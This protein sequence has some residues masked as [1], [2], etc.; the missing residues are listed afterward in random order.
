MRR[1]VPCLVIAL[2]VLAACAKK[3]AA[4]TEVD[5]RVTAAAA[6]M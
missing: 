5:S 6:G 2:L 3:K 1:L 4:P